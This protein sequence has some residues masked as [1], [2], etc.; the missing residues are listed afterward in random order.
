MN[1]LG[2]LGKKTLDEVRKEGG[3]QEM[4]SK[5]SVAWFGGKTHTQIAEW[6]PSDVLENNVLEDIDF[7]IIGW[8]K[9]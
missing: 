4:D 6:L 9:G 2:N 8:R 7:L 1:H 3:W 5:S